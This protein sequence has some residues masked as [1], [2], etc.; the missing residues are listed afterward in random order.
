MPMNEQPMPRVTPVNRPYWE[1]CNRGMLMIQRCQ[2]ASCGRHVFYPRVCCPHCGGGDLEWTAVSGR[3]T[4][5]SYT[6]VYRPQH[7]SFRSEVP[8]CFVAVR[9]D[10]GPILYSRLVERPSPTMELVGRAVMIVFSESI[11]GQR[12]PY[13]RLA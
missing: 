7:D 12:L 11:N 2:A 1:A 8:I 9:L 4:L 3:G 10:E 5:V 6:D 13:V